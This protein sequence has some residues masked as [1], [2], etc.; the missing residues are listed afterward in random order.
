MKQATVVMKLIAIAS[1]SFCQ[2]TTTNSPLTKIDYLTKSKHQR[3]AAW[4]LLGGGTAL[5]VTGLSIGINSVYD[6]FG[7][8]I[9]NGQ[10]DKS[11]VAGEV[12]F[13]TGMAAILSSIPLF[14][15]S[16]HNKRKAMAASTSFKIETAP[17]IQ[18]ANF[19]YRTVPSL[20]LKICL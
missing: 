2:Q 6:E 16:H 19:V 18:H 10:D 12:L 5:T 4:I 3:T 11:Y 14:I 1:S 20:N 17:V 13:Y 9:S 8:I 15:A 7:S